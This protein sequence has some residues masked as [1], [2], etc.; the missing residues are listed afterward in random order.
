MPCKAEEPVQPIYNYAPPYTTAFDGARDL[1][2][3]RELALGYE[4]EL[5]AA[6]RS[7]K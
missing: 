2:V 5:R 7:C 1:L 4:E 3:D 6:L